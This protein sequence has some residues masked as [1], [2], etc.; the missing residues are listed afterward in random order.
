MLPGYSQPVLYAREQ[1]EMQEQSS[2]VAWFS[3]EILHRSSWYYMVG[4]QAKTS[5]CMHNT[6][7][8]S[9]PPANLP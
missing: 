7:T 8:A 9:V 4:V 6:P 5:M 3:A 2:T 1:A